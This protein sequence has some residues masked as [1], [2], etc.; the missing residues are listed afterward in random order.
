[1]G[2]ISRYLNELKSKTGYTQQQIA[3]ITGI[4]IGTVP[5]YFADMDDD[6]ANFEIVRKLV[7]AMG[8]SLDELAGIAPKQLE[9]NAEKHCADGYTDAER[10]VILRW[11]G[12]EI[13]RS[14]QAIVAGLEAR[15]AEKDE[16]LSHRTGLME[17]EHQ[18]AREDVAAERQRAMIEIQHE[19]KRSM[20]CLVV[21]FASLGTLAGLFVIDFLLPTV[22]WIRR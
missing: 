13:S 2:R 9:I 12:N 5:R 4:P 8:G 1:M 16:R 15:I 17:V 10:K 20:I 18:R 7:S 19:R 21:A 22:G 14:Y 3:E 6:T 11:A